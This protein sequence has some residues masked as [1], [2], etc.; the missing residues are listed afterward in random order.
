M[1]T[2]LPCIHVFTHCCQW[3]FH[4]P[5]FHWISSQRGKPPIPI[6]LL[7]LDG[8][9]N[10]RCWVLQGHWGQR[11]CRGQSAPRIAN[12]ICFFAISIMQRKTGPWTLSRHRNGDDPPQGPSRSLRLEL[13]SCNDPCPTTLPLGEVHLFVNALALVPCKTT[14]SM[15]HR[16]TSRHSLALR[17][18]CQDS[19]AM[20]E[21]VVSPFKPLARVP[22]KLN[23]NQ[24]TKVH[25]HFPFFGSYI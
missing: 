22:D 20:L 15:V 4:I 12:H 19:S 6:T 16:S 2:P 14:T 24:R 10:I 8:Q 1:L 23:N 5:I 17:R 11:R 21:G 13:L 18:I 25:S 3:P 9:C 7:V